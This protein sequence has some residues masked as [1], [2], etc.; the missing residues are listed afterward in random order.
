MKHITFT[1][2]KKIVL[3]SLTAILAMSFTPLESK[4]AIAPVRTELA[5]DSAGT[6]NTLLT[7][8]DE[9]KTMDKSSLTSKEKR[10]LRA[11]VRSINKNMHDNYGG[12]YISVGGL[13]LIILLIIILL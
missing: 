10:E 12:I 13:L 3:S 7:R 1:N 6:L 5:A 11:E 9:I 2:T 4:A 8:L